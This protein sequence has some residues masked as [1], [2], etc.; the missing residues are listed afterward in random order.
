MIKIQVTG[1]HGRPPAHEVSAEF[2]ELGGSI[3]RAPNNHLVLPDP[4]RHI[5]RTQAQ[6]LFQAGGYLIVD[7]GTSNPV[8]VNGQALGKGNRQELRD[9]DELVIGSYK[10][11]V[12]E[13][14]PDLL[15][16]MASVGRRP[17]AEQPKDRPVDDPLAMFGAS[18]AAST[19]PFADLMRPS[20][21]TPPANAPKP[22]PVERS[23]PASS[24][25]RGAAGS[26][27]LIPDDFDPFADPMAAPPVARAAGAPEGVPE[28]LDLGPKTPSSQGIDALFGLGPAAPHDPFALG[29]PLG[30][31]LAQPNTS[32]VDDPLA[33]L[34]GAPSSVPPAAMSDHVPELH[35]A[36]RPPAAKPERA[37]QASPAAEIK[38]E[39]NLSG[40][41]PTQTRSNLA[42]KAPAAPRGGAPAAAG[43]APME[44]RP[45]P[46]A[47][48]PKPQ[49]AAAQQPAAGT[50]A[51]L[52]AFLDGAG[53]PNLTLAGGLTPETMRLIG[54]LL[55]EATLGTLDLLQARMMIKREVRAQATMIVARDNNPLKFS[56]DV[57]SALGHLLAPQ[58][59]GFMAPLASM[60]D[61]Y[62][63]LRSHEFGFMAGMRAALAGVLARFGPEELEK[64]LKQKSFLDGLVPMT[65]KARLWDLFAEMYEEISREAEDDFHAVFGREFLRAYEEQV[66]R[67]EKKQ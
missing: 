13:S 57:D 53:I 48:A 18:P 24:P 46:V 10:L 35:G 50:E 59:R 32:P 6:I 44:K 4:D 29:H 11:K 14:G 12:S 39:L 65:R 16:G 45:A 51:L 55:R 41:I 40:D 42:V 3:G 49:P 66:A 19:D 1:H 52:R 64:R 33:A 56:P 37:A 60:Q 25:A 58:G 34:G 63:D 20:A 36:F 5:S 21:A 17:A 9:G 43:S 2:D 54:A 28:D 23:R 27:N 8:I 26:A 67:L 31:P 62:D 30:E 47:P 61:A 38:T 15:K 22:P 7:E